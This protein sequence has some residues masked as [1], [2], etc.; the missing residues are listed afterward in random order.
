VVLDILYI[1]I[2]LK[3]KKLHCIRMPHAIL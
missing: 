3:K 1:Y 2:S